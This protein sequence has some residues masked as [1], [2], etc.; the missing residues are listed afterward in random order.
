MTAQWIEILRNHS[1]GA[2]E[3]P[4][5]DYP[6]FLDALEG[7]TAAQAAWKPS[8]E[9]HSIWQIADHLIKS[10]EWERQMIEGQR[11]APPPWGDPTGDDNAWQATI[12]RLR[13]AQA[14]LLQAIEHLTV[15]DLM[16]RPPTRLKWSV[17]NLILNK[18]AHDA[19][20][21]GQI[22]YLRALQGLG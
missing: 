12:Q 15:D 14:R 4:N 9:R 19:Y 16:K 1:M 22:R 2:F 20:H 8:P 5:G 18:G 10:K 17:V 3:G 11:P 6:S 13:D 21:A 7:L